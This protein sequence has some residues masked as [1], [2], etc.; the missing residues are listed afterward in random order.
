[1]FKI[2]RKNT[3]PQLCTTKQNY[4]LPHNHELGHI[5]VKVKFVANFRQ[6]TRSYRVGAFKILCSR[7]LTKRL[8]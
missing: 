4:K 3:I 1:M 6:L 8:S 5:A 2:L 7:F